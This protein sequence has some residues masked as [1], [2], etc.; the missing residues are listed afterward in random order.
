MKSNFKKLNLYIIIFYIY[1]K[2]LIKCE[3]DEKICSDFQD[4]FNCTMCGNENSKYCNCKWKSIGSSESCVQDETR[5]LSEWYTELTQCKN[6]LEQLLYCSGEGTVYSK[7]DLS[8]DNSITFQIN[9]DNKGIYGKKML[10]CKYT[11]TDETAS[12]YLLNILFSSQLKNKPIVAYGCNFTE[13]SQDKI[14]KIE[15]DKEIS[16]SSSV[17]IF[18]VALLKEEYTSSP[19]IFKITLKNLSISKYIKAFCI[20][21]IILLIITFTI[22]CISR[23]YN[24][25]ARRQLRMLMIQRARENMLRIEQENNN[26]NNYNENN[27]NLEEINKEKLD[28]LFTK[29]M[30]E[31]LYKSEYNQYGGGCS[32]C[33]ENFK[34][35]D[36]VSVTPCNHVFHYKCI[37][38]WLYKNVKNPKCPNCN[39]EV[40]VNDE[41]DD[42]TKINENQII[43]VNKK[44]NNNNNNILNQNLNFAGRNNVSYNIN[45]RGANSRLDFSHSQRQHL[46]EN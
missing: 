32:I 42:K 9:K 2:F 14:Q 36:K 7:D 26:I 12:D 40:L 45:S 23:F 13:S 24:N 31:H 34:K 41:N 29:K 43:K 39:K 28:K 35:K 18:F 20:A 10:F 37:K 1:H 17:N 38:D 25:K 16:C 46:G 19:V 15:E 8:E 6:N 3:N 30:A 21:I 4:C 5:Y 33:L 44:Q 27:E 22:Y 11:F